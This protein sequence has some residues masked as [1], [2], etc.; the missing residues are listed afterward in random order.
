MPFIHIVFWFTLCLHSCRLRTYLTSMMFQ[1]YGMSRLFLEWV[2]FTGALT[3]AINILSMYCLHLVLLATQILTSVILQNQKAHEAIIKQLNLAGWVRQLLE[4]S[5]NQC[6]LRRLCLDSHKWQIGV[7]WEQWRRQG[8]APV[9]L[10]IPKIW[11]KIL[12]RIYI[13]ILLLSYCKECS[14][15]KFQTHCSFE[16]IILLPLI[17]STNC[18]WKSYYLF[19]FLDPQW[20]HTHWN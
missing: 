19:G 16:E 4:M 2:I 6:I 7:R 13:C 8:Y 11:R 17:T 12:I 5:A 9:C 18:D 15:R 14:F 20:I 1:I 10:G 3:F